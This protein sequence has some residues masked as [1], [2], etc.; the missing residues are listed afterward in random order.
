MLLRLIRLGWDLSA[1][2]GPVKCRFL[3]FLVRHQPRPTDIRQYDAQQKGEA[4]WD[5]F[6]PYLVGDGPTVTVLD[7]DLNPNNILDSAQ[8]GSVKVDWS[9]SGV[10]A[11]FVPIVTF[12]VNV[13]AESM[14]PGPE[15]TV[16]TQVV[17]PGA[18]LTATIAITSGQ[19]PAGGAT[20][21]GVYRLTTVITSSIVFPGVPTIQLPLA[22]FVDGPTIQMR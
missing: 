2:A 14:G 1:L 15:V 3:M 6:A 4:M 16:G 10:L 17:S 19:L 9:F 11:G 5:D 12:T 20:S 22:A 7:P 13:Y 8:G 21:S 18:P